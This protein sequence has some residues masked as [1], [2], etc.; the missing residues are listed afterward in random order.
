MEDRRAAYLEAGWADAVIVPPT[1]HFSSWEYQ[2]AAKRKGGRVYIDIRAN[3]EVTFHEGY[4]SRKEAERARRGESDEAPRD[5]PARPELTGPMQ[6]YIDLHRHAAVRATLLGYPAIA[7]RLMVAHALAGSHL[8]GLR[9][10]PQDTRRDDVRE[11]VEVS[12]ARSAFDERRRAVLALLGFASEEP[13]VIG[14]GE[15]GVAGIFA[16]LMALP[17]ACV[18]EVVAIVMGE[19]LAAGSAAVE[20]AAREIGVDMAD[21]W[22][23]DE[24]F[25]ALLRDKEVTTALVAEVA[26]DTVATANAGETVKAQKA[27]LS[28]HLTG[29]NGRAKVEHWVPRWMRF[30]PEAYTERG[31]VGTVAAHSEA[32][33]EAERA[34]EIARGMG[35]LEAAFET[36]SESGAETEPQ[37]EAA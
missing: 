12:K 20:A 23:A 11:S 34:E 26:G 25:F 37:R 3:G 10:E 31:G 22:E 17:D 6:N 35:E 30:P 16:R 32:A 1:A 15:L 7:L 21:W 19:T 24:A 28:D 4:V 36:P 9:V 8:W 5:K 14:G 29:S 27:V 13:T 33:Y 18:M 2:K